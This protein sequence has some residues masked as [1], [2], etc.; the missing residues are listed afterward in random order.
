MK[1]YIPIFLVLALV[2]CA[3]DAK[4][5]A[6]SSLAVACESYAATLTE[7]AARKATLTVSQ[8]GTVDR[9]RAV[10]NPICLPDSQVD[11]AAAVGFVQS[12]LTLLKSF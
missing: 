6:T 1:R 3:G 11:P 9:V 7:L 4:T 2:A 12:S 8:V 5:R 10:V